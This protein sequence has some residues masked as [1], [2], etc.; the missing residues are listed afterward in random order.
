MAPKLEDFEESIVLRG[1]Q[2]GD[3]A[4]WAELMRKCFPGLKPW[5]EEQLASMLDH[6]DEGQVCIE[7]EGEIVAACS[8]LIIK[9]DDYTDWH[10]Y[11]QIA[12]EG[13]IRNHDAEG[14]T[15]YGIE[16]MVHP[17]YRGRKLARRL[18]DHRKQLCRDKRCAR[19]IIGGRI[20]GYVTHRQTL[21]AREYVEKVMGKELYDPVLT[22]QIANGFQLRELVADYLPSDEDSA[23]Y[24][25]ILEWP[26]LDHMPEGTRRRRSRRAVDIARLGFVQYGMRRIASFDE[27]ERQCAFFVDAASD[28]KADVLL[29]PELFTTQ[30]LS[31]IEEGRPEQ[32]ARKLAELTPRYLELFGRLARDYNIN[33]IGGSQLV[34]EEDGSL[35]NVAFLFRRDGTIAQQ[36]K[37]HITPDE[38]KWW[39]VQGGDKV[40]VFETDIGP[41]AILICYDIEFPELAR[42]V[43]ERGARVIF[44]PSNTFD[45]RGHLRVK[46]CAQA[47]CIENQIF[48]VTAGPVGNL[49]L[50]ANADTHYYQSGIYTPSDIAF[51]RDGFD[52]GLRF[53]GDS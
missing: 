22:T 4:A 30:L 51:A 10:D 14:D 46:L 53:G 8:S 21:S 52:G 19:M 16:M 27:F 41:I 3:Y 43:V 20:P 12:D 37:I 38:A 31:L 25:T 2:L 33:I 35:Y 47:R 26:N 1:L 7:I 23:G 6:F 49:P 34:T 13:Y 17:D 29:F 45:R 40:E 15:L 32:D 11:M 9:Y 39:G 18:Y 24:A 42:Y 48:V 28:Q 50:L 44:V 5:N 36:K